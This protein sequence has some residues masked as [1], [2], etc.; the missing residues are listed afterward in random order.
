MDLPPFV[1]IQNSSTG[2][3]LESNEEGDVYACA[4][5]MDGYQKW[6]T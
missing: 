2:L 1:H 6:E 4:K 5:S 3:Y